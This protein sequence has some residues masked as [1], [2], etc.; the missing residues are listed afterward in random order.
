MVRLNASSSMTSPD[1]S[2]VR[3]DEEAGLV[4]ENTKNFSVLDLLKSK[5]SNLSG[6]R[7]LFIFVLATLAFGIVFD[8]LTAGKS[9]LHLVVKRLQTGFIQCSA[10]RHGGKRPTRSFI[11]WRNSNLEGL[12]ELKMSDIA[13]PKLQ[14][15][16]SM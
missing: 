7:K 11:S 13:Q 1:R 6:Q 2:V 15:T 5:I 14:R 12:S 10:S 16:L 9:H 8:E 3:D 4:S